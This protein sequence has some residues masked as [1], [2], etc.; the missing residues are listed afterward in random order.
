MDIAAGTRASRA[1]DRRSTACDEIPCWWPG[2]NCAK[3]REPHQSV[4]TA[5]LTGTPAAA[6]RLQRAADCHV[7]RA[8]CDGSQPT[9]VT[10]SHVS[11]GQRQQRP[12]RRSA[13]IPWCG[14]IARQSVC[15]FPS[16]RM[17]LHLPDVY[18]PE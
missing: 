12:R 7:S 18:L 4:P 6:D 15:L 3:A 14:M 13:V 17:P 5:A 1:T 2:A 8:T 9:P 16:I 11:H 10:R